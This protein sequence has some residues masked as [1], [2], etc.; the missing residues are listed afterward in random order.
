MKIVI[1]YDG[2]DHAKAAV[3]DLTRSGL[4]QDT[5]AVVV[6]VADV[7]PVSLERHSS[8]RVAKSQSGAQ[9]QMSEAQR[10]AEEGARQTRELFPSWR[11]SHQAVADS[12][13][14]AFIKHADDINADLIVLG[15][16]G[17]TGLTATALGSVSQNVLANASCSVRVGRG[18]GAAKAGSPVRI[19][20]G[21]DGSKGA[22]AAVA[23]VAQRAWPQ[24][25]EARLVTASHGRTLALMFDEEPE[26][27]DF[28]AIVDNAT[29]ALESRLKVTTSQR[30]DDPKSLILREAE[31]WRADV[32]FLGARGLTR[33][34]R[35]LLG[36]VAG[37]IAARAKC[38][39][40]VVRAD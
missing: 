12:P 14:W 3:A 40:E 10:V 22:D 17:R 9:K 29:R 25:S 4:P 26:K 11:V 16:R 18:A 39:V 38:S 32:I 35:S 19:L 27:G 21:L 5:E 24:G 34:E 30:E 7:L 28:P 2:S 15:S 20:I 36:S 6:S 37:A 8:P 1:A 23:S 33:T 31:E 13:Y